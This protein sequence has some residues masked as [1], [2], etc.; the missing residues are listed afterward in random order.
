MLGSA[1]SLVRLRDRNGTELTIREEDDV[2]KRTLGVD[3]GIR[4]AHVATLCDEEGEVVWTGKRFR[5]RSEE[6]ATLSTRVGADEGLLVV[7]EPTRNV[8]VPVA[9]HFMALGAEVIL[10]A[11]ER[12]ADLRRYYAKHTKNDRVDSMVLARLPQL[13][14]EGLNPIDGLGP[15]EPLR[16]AV[17]RRVKLVEAR[18]ASRQRLDALL[19]L[20][21]PGYARVLGAARFTK[22]ALAVLEGY[23]DPRR[24]RRLGA[25]RLAALMRRTS[26]GKWGAEQAGELIDAAAEAIR[27][28]ETGGL[29]FDELAWDLSAEIRIIGN[30]DD[31][32]T[33]LEERIESLYEKADPQGI[34]I[35]APGVGVVL[36]GGILGRLGDAKRFGD[37]AGVR[38]FSGMIPA[39]NQT[40]LTQTRPGI[41]KRGDAG[42]RRDIWI[43]A[44][45][46]RHIDPQLAAKYHRL[47]VERRLHHYSAI[48]HLATTLLTRIAACWR[49]DERYVIR[50]VDGRRI[51]PTEGR[52]IVQARYRIPPQ[53]R[54]RSRIP[55]TSGSAQ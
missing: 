10:V 24:L 17:R 46:A 15:A 47:I 18:L 51:T 44:D 14:P 43:A 37:L 50:D 6:L 12:A 41:T 29:D 2:A 4:G 27:L 21:G 7:M 45:I 36:A 20:L 31:E 42:L 48:C 5:T 55:Q 1:Q 53:S 35:S 16:R 22:T 52:A 32:I 3:L 8:W 38:A 13:H 19:D 34:V 40:G 54:Q 23:G 25:N 39:V 9:A 26:G 11:P 33:Q 28:W 49:R 30:L